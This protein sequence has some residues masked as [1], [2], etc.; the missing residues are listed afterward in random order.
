MT[1]CDQELRITEAERRG[2]SE[3]ERKARE[4]NGGPTAHRWGTVPQ[5][6]VR[7]PSD[8]VTGKCRT[9]PDVRAGHTPRT[10]FGTGGMFRGKAREPA[11][12]IP[13]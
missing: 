2:A 5:G 6:R 7:R 11:A 4:D 8:V 13:R 9:P 3:G 12:P 10:A 1:K